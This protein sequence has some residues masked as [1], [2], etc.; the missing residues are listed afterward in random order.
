MSL[1]RN[2]TRQSAFLR[3][4]TRRTPQITYV[5]TRLAHQDYGG[6]GI[7]GEKPE[8]Q[9]KNPSEHLEHPGPPSPA[10]GNNSGSSG[11]QQGGS[12]S[13]SSSN[14]SSQD[15]SKQPQQSQ[16]SKGTQGAQPKI[17]NESPPKEGS[18]SAD[19]EQ[20]NRELDQRAEQAHEKVRD[21]DIEKDKVGKGFWSGKF[22]KHC[23]DRR[24]L[25]C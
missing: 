21:E 2:M 20:H 8:T 7:A 19:V 13:S 4:L 18:A 14:Q 25:R 15:S 1:I 17:L 6:S 23:A 12:S 9:G 16:P 11:Q 10:T 24:S 3:P 5:N 22:M